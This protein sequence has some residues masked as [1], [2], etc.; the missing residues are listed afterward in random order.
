MEKEEK[1][2]QNGERKMC[3]HVARETCAREQH[4]NFECLNWFSFNETK[5]VYASAL[6]LV[7]AVR[8]CVRAREQA[9]HTHRPSVCSVCVVATTTHRLT[10]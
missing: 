9:L 3:A 10:D 6:E 5:S 1:E 8:S 2:K 4:D 7:C